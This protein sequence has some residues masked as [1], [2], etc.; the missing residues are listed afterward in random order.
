MKELIISYTRS[1]LESRDG[2]EWV[3]ALGAYNGHVLCVNTAGQAFGV[4]LDKMWG[5]II[6]EQIHIRWGVRSQQ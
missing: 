3:P 4:Q 6:G 1:P 2:D 5:A